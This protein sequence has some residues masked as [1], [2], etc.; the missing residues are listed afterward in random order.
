M[1]IKNYFSNA[2]LIFI[3]FLS[4]CV[5][6]KNE[7]RNNNQKA[8]KKF[9]VISQSICDSALK[10]IVLKEISRTLNYPL[11]A[12]DDQVKNALADIELDVQVEI[13]IA[14]REHLKVLIK[15]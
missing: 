12:N 4:G 7:K 1:R 3:V 9:D 8:N 14:Q 11:E 5:C 6:S 15:K 13:E 2:F 10:N